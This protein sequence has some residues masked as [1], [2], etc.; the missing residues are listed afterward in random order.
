MKQLL[1][2]FS[3]EVGTIKPVNGVGQPPFS[4]INFSMIDYLK[5]ANIPYSRL[6]DVGGAFGGNLYVDIPNVFRDFNADPK[7]PESYDFA[8]T[9]LLIKNLIERG[10][11]P[12]YRLG[13]TIENSRSIKPYRIHPPADFKKWAEICEGIIRHYNEGWADG[14]NYNIKYWEIW[15]EPDNSETSEG[16]HMW[17]GTAEDYY[18]L[19]DITSKH[20]KEKFPHIKIGGYGSCGFYELTMA[21]NTYANSTPRHKYFIEFFDGFLDYIIEHKTPLDFFSWHSYATIED[22]IVWTEYVRRRL[23]EAGYKDTEHSLNEWNVG[24]DVPGTTKHAAFTA[25]NMLAMQN[26]SLDTAMFYDARCGASM[27]SALFNC[28]TKKPYPSYY[29]MVAFGELYIRKTQVKIEGELPEK[30]YAV[31]A[32]DKDGCLLISNTNEVDY[33]I[34]LSLVGAGKISECKIITENAVWEDYNF[35][36]HLPKETVIFLKYELD[37]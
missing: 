14:F 12:V 4:G 15:N 34:N 22:N 20:L 9:D 30:V 24:P 28:L 11:E 26:T 2:D 1:V 31:A 6:H 32:K 29:S 35:D 33:D 16:N 21:D 25:G 36:G 5:D 18:R 27:F 3:K 7:D 10:V 8:F 23:D 17:T 19:Y 37:V 13:V